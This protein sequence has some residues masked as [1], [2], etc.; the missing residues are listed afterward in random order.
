LAWVT[1]TVNGSNDARV[2]IDG[3][4]VPPAAIGVRRA[5]N[6]GARMVRVTAT[7][8]L[9][10]KMPLDLAEGGEG[11]A[12]FNLEPDPEAAAKPAPPPVQD[13]PAE[14][15]AHDPTLTYVAFGVGG[16]GLIVGG[17]TGALA[18]SKH[19]ALS[20]V[21]H[22]NGD[23]RSQETSTLNSY[24]TFGTISGI[25]FGV[26]LAG[27]GAGVALWLMNRNAAPAP[28]EHGLLIKPYVGVGSVGALGSF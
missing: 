10:Q 12:D 7:G 3:T 1:I 14:Q 2:T 5:V 17:V 19:S 20:K 8:F 23:C 21:C 4:A 18:L 11:S 9:P 28:A 26:G 22:P 16:A 25:G 27:V 24:H 6:P 15:Q 13:A